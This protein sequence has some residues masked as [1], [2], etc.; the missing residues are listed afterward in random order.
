MPKVDICIDPMFPGTSLAERARRVADAGFPAVEFWF[1]DLKFDRP[2]KGEPV[3]AQEGMKRVAELAEVCRDTGVVVNNIVVNA[4]DAGIGGSLV[5]PAD[6]PKYLKR[7]AETIKVAKDLGCSK[8]ITCTG[9]ARLGVSRG[10]QH[11]S[12]VDTL[13]AAA[14]IAAPAGVTLFL[15]PLNTLV[16]HD[17]YFLDS[18]DEG[19]EIVREVASPNV[20][21]LYDVYH[22]QIM[23]GNVLARIEN[24]IDI[25]GHFHSAGVPGRHELSEGELNYPAILKKID[26]LGYNGYF[27]LEYWPA[28]DDAE[29][30]RQMRELTR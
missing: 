28:L 25:I 10:E 12:V 8:M 20:K 17:G 29:S 1:Y 19:A 16:D 6:R 26:S 14:E 24:Y 4:P 3:S 9:N 21:L 13:K 7:L 15:E 27:G 23:Q 30:L 18:A 22:M 11:K 5:D 2:D